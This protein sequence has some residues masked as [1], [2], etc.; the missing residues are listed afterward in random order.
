V[1]PFD[2]KTKSRKSNAS[3]ALRGSYIVASWPNS[4]DEWIEWPKW[5]DKRDKSLEV[6][7][8]V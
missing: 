7:S 1:K 4:L 5:F 8:M 2:E 6:G 3:V